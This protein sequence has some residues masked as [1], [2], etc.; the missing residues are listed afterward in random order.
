MKRPTASGL[1]AALSLAI[2]LSACTQWRYELGS[3]L[4]PEM[5]PEDA[6]N[7]SLS[8]VLAR[9]GPP[10]RLSAAGEG[11]VLA[12]EFWKIRED[13]IGLSLGAMGADL[14]SVDWGTSHMHGQFLLVTFN[15]QHRVTGQ[16]YSRWNSDGGSGRAHHPQS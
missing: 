8:E 11:Y 6:G 14:L 16:A 4:S 7:L 12:W 10:L 2:A 3:Q 5:L 9:L 1:L 13:T 15:R